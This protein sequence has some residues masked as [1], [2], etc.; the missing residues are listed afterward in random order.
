MV[1]IYCGDQLGATFLLHHYIQ[2]PA[3]DCEASQVSSKWEK[4]LLCML[5]NSPAKVGP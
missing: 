4:L 5:V 1:E 3:L 2:Q